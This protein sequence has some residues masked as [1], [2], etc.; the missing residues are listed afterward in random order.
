MKKSS[1]LF[2]SF[3]LVHV[4]AFSVPMTVKG[5]IQKMIHDDEGI[6]V[7]TLKEEASKKKT[8][9]L[10]LKNTHPDFVKISAELNKAKELEAKVVFSVDGQSLNTI[11]KVKVG[12]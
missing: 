2:L 7:L 4:S 9:A 3:L 5:R 8:Q 1:F 10:Y 6:K 12:Q 11:E